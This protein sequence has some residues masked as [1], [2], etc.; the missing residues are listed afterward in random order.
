MSRINYAVLKELAR[1]Q[2]CRVTDL[3]ALAPQNDPFYCGSPGEVDKAQWFAELWRTF[4][5]S[6]GVHLRRVHYQLISQPLPCKADGQP[7]QNTENDWNYLLNAGKYARYLGLVDPNAFEDRRNPDPMVTAYYYAEEPPG[8]SVDTYH[9]D[10]IEAPTWPGLPGF[11]VQGFD[12]NLQPYHMEVWVE[13]TT[14]NDVLR[15]LCSRYRANLV[16]GAGEMSITAVLDL[17][18]RVAQADRPARIFYVSDFDPAGYGMPISVARKIEFL[19]DNLDQTMDIRLEPVALT[20]GQV[21]EYSLPRTPIKDTELRRGNFEDIH[22]EG[23]VELDALEALYPGAL[24]SIVDEYLDRYY[25]HEIEDRLQEGKRLLRD[26]LDEVTEETVRSVLEDN[27]EWAD[28]ED[29]F[30]AAVTEFMNAIGPIQHDLSTF[31]EVLTD[32]LNGFSYEDIDPEE[33]F[34][35]EVKQAEEDDRVLFDSKRDYGQQLAAYKIHRM[36]GDG[37]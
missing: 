20:Q 18:K 32:R 3:I 13:K 10:E 27:P 22:G 4:G 25:D 19:V 12:A 8:F 7:Y 33:Y 6:T 30:D 1:Q 14:M 15:P 5:Y 29:R 11:R 17:I 9:L 35:Q 24:R 26:R 37:A 31:T 23:A 16:T 34:P 21:Q 36:G 2:G 28:L